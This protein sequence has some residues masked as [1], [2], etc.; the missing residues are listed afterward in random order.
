MIL[1]YKKII[2]TI[3]DFIKKVIINKK[4]VISYVGGFLGKQN[5]G[6]EALYIAIKHYFNKFN[7]IHFD[8]SRTITTLFKRF[9][10]IKGGILAGG[11]LINRVGWYDVAEDFY[12]LC[13]SLYIF[14]TGVAN[15]S[16]WLGKPSYSNT[17]DKWKMLLEKCQYVG[18]RG[19]I[20]AEILV[21]AGVKNVEVIGDP[22]LAFADDK[23]GNSYDLN[24]IGL[25]IGH[26]TEGVWGDKTT[27]YREY[28]KLACL[29]KGANW[30]VKWFVVS[31]NDLEMTQRIASDSNTSTFIYKIYNDPMVYIDLIRPLSTFVGM[32]LHATILATCAYV[33]SI[34]L[35]YRPKCRDYMKSIGQ[36]HA[37]IRTDEFKAI[38]TWEIVN[39]WNSQRYENAKLLFDSIKT[40]RTKQMLK[41]DAITSQLL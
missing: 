33:P 36:D 16:F 21:D 4:P 12:E 17:M 37:T 35:E 14:G 18:V 38:H 34:M 10:S 2:L 30:T 28:V 39:N 7:F 27:I 3:T 19:P 8:Q 23:L 31:P 40:L 26:D 20:S 32:K 9:Q 1:R 6:D 13:P 25:N 11:T 41:A 29:A 24:S 22:V 15:P 5:L